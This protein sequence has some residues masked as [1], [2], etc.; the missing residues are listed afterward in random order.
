MYPLVRL[1]HVYPLV[2]LLH[3]YPLVRL[4]HVYPLVRLLHVY[5][6]VRLLHVYPLVRLLHVYPLVRLLHV[7][8]LVRLLHV[9]PWIRLLPVKPRT[10]C[11][12]INYFRLQSARDV[13]GAGRGKLQT[14][15]MQ[16]PLNYQ[17][18][19][20]HTIRHTPTCSRVGVNTQELT[21]YNSTSDEDLPKLKT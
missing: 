16:F 6:L 13:T 20:T 19:P 15:A 10:L 11:K 2:R 21:K 9:F 1:L 3:V 14:P 18:T 12:I 7:Y 4:L 5:S 8:P 17:D